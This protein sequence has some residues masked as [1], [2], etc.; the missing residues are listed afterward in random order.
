MGTGDNGDKE[1]PGF[2]ASRGLTIILIAVL[3]ILAV[4]FIWIQASGG[5][6]NFFDKFKKKKKAKPELKP[7]TMGQQMRHP[8]EYPRFEFADNGLIIISRSELV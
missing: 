6:S 7:P 3:V 2:L 5:F 8:V 4:A 1:K